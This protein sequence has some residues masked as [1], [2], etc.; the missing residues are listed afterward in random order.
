VRFDRDRPDR[1]VFSSPRGVDIPEIPPIMAINGRRISSRTAGERRWEED[2]P[3]GLYLRALK[4]LVMRLRRRRR[5]L[6]ADAGEEL[7]GGLGG[8]VLVDETVA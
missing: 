8:R 1:P 5:A 4:P 3:L 7:G 6:G 2:V